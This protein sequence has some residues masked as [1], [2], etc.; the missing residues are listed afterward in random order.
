[1]I[2]GYEFRSQAP[3]IDTTPVSF[4]LFSS[5]Q[6]AGPLPNLHSSMSSTTGPPF[7]NA[8]NLVTGVYG[9]TV[10]FNALLKAVELVWSERTFAGAESNLILVYP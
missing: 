5:Y 1:M 4:A 2:S 7:K 10:S 6:E 3:A 8:L 9:Y